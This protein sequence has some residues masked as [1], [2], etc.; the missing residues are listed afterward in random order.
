MSWQSF[1]GEAVVG[2]V[3]RKQCGWRMAAGRAMVVH[4]AISLGLPTSLITPTS[5]ALSEQGSNLPEH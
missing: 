4:G 2:M 1:A 3:S 5:P